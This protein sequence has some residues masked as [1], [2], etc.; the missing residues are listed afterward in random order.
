MVD[1]ALPVGTRIVSKETY[2]R[3]GKTE[4]SKVYSS[5]DAVLLAIKNRHDGPWDE[6]EQLK[7]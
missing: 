3:A 4:V 7:E 1:L 5:D 2:Y 6:T